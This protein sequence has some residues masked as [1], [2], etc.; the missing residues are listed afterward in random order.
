MTK[1]IAEIGWNHMGNI[2][3]AKKMIKSAKN[4][5]ADY[6]KTQIFDTK[7]LTPGPWD[8]D[9]RK[10][11]YWKAQLTKK[12]YGILHKYSKKI[13]IKLFSSVVNKK[14][15]DL[16]KNF[17]NSLIK[18]PSA[19]NRDLD[20]INYSLKY[21]RK[22]IISLGATN[23]ND[24]KKIIR[25]SKKRGNKNK[26]ILLHCV[27]VYPCTTE[28]VNLPKINMLKKY[29]SKIGFSDHTENI[30]SSVLSLKFN[31]IM[32]EKHFTIDQKLPGRDNKLSIL[33]DQLN[34]IK[35]FIKISNKSKKFNGF[36]FLKGEKII[37]DVYSKRWSG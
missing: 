24:I 7:Y 11:I 18:I 22:V 10:K 16:L 4:N 12:K 33:P 35:T 31:P 25:I 34:Q 2:N 29:Y 37:R 6:V 36:G 3:I 8:K 13:G 5:G 20:L 27:S 9:G 14:G 17:Q 15:V 23:L 30:Y 19:H 28:E 21:F 26:I 32:I 1:L